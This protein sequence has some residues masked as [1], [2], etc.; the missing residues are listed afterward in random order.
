MFPL[1]SLVF[2]KSNDVQYS[3]NS[4]RFK[5]AEARWL[6]VKVYVFI[7]HLE[8][9]SVGI[10]ETGCRLGFSVKVSRVSLCGHDHDHGQRDKEHNT[11]RR[12]LQGTRC[13]RG[14]QRERERRWRMTG[15]LWPLTPDLDRRI[16]ESQ[17]T[18]GEVG[19]KGGVVSG[20][21]IEGWKMDRIPADGWGQPGC[22]HVEIHS[23]GDQPFWR[24]HL[25][26]QIFCPHVFQTRWA[27][28]LYVLCKSGPK[29]HSLRH[30]TSFRNVSNV[31]SHSLQSFG[32]SSIECSVYLCQ[33]N[34]INTNVW[35]MII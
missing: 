15:N 9:S 13:K 30:I 3:C 2:S 24:M 34:Q 12:S 33:N 5:Y 28:D 31:I 23:K 14:M 22:H 29:Y 10:S 19:G 16:L 1:V 25:L 26:H 8:S 32:F 7:F 27:A 4:L 17:Q 20:L 6:I 21:I 11:E 35:I 18:H